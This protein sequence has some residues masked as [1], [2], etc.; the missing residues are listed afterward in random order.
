MFKD[1]KFNIS[2]I[3]SHRSQGVNYTF[4]N[5]ATSPRGQRV[6]GLELDALISQGPPDTIVVSVTRGMSAL[7]SVDIVPY[8]TYNLNTLA[9]SIGPD[10]L[11]GVIFRVDRPCFNI[12]LAS[13]M[14]V[15]VPAVRKKITMR[16]PGWSSHNALV[17]SQYGSQSQITSMG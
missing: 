16:T 10:K 11:M 8:Q 14:W 3:L 2:N 6:N 9:V 13:G 17:L 7:V 15:N 5:I 1:G 12:F 4:K